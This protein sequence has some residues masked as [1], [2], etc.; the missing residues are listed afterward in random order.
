M[1]NFLAIS[2]GISIAAIAVTTLNFPIL[3]ISGIIGF[4]FIKEQFEE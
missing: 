1:K 3:V 4:L 2:G